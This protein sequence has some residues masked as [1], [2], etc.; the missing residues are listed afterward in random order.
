[1]TFENFK[2]IYDS[3]MGL[4]KYFD[5][6]Y[7]LKIDIINSPILTYFTTLEDVSIE[8]EYGKDGLDWYTWFVYEKMSHENPDEFNAYDENHNVI[9][10]T[11][12]ELYD[13]LEKKCNKNL[14]NTKK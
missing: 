3:S 6:L 1:M 12:E 5:D 11:L 7:N 8:N 13:Y 4:S 10:R 2:K 9:L 14:D